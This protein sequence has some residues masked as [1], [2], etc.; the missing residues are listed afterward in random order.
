MRK[1]SELAGLPYEVV[2][3]VN[4]LFNRF[5]EEVLECRDLVEGIDYVM[6]A[7]PAVAPPAADATL[8]PLHLRKSP[9]EGPVLPSRPTKRYATPTVEQIRNFVAKGLS[10]VLWTEEER[11]KKS[12]VC[13]KEC[14]SRTATLTEQ[15]VS[16]T[17]RVK[18]GMQCYDSLQT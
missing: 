13:L 12:T 18:P 17:S 6:D 1:P 8:P 4:P 7:E 11:A 5:R 3:Y 2:Q 15:G 10:E 14:L 9:A 16:L